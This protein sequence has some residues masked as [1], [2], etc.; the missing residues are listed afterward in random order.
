MEAVNNL[1]YIVYCTTNKV[2]GKIYIGVHKTYADSF[3]G[4]IGC[5]VYINK[6]NTYEQS[7]TIFQR[8]VKK[9]GTAQFIRKTLAEFATEEEAMA[10]EEELVN[11]KFLEREDVYNMI[12][13]GYGN[14]NMKPK[15]RCY[16]YD[17]TGKFI[18]EFESIREAGKLVSNSDY[19]F[20]SVKNA[21]IDKIAYRNMFW[22]FIKTEQLDI[23]EYAL[24]RRPKVKVYQYKASGE[25]E[26]EYESLKE[27]SQANNTC[28][29]SLDKAC[30]LGYLSKN[31]YFSF[32]K[33]EQFSTAKLEYLKTVPVYCY[34]I[35]GN[36]LKKYQNEKEAVKDLN[37]KGS[38]MKSL[39]LKCAHN[40][41][42]QFSFEY[43]DKMPNRKLGEIKS[44]KKKI[45]QYDLEGNFIKTW[46]SISECCKE[47]Q[48]QSSSINKVLKGIQHKTK[49]FTFKYH[50]D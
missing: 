42:Y 15:F 12:L 9:Y 28:A 37:I 26:C 14:K 25:F 39:R 4:Y 38:I 36:F 45:D 19:S 34:D 24:N 30:K 3:D 31:K 16:C 32:E 18:K 17:L 2:N 44:T 43:L 5:G 50:K 33:H 11:A 1:K 22:S 35:E 40:N 48:I 29:S 49:N 10:L 20:N 47:L 13:G 6:P 23:S 21:I 8:A 27:A 7:K 46:S 41:K